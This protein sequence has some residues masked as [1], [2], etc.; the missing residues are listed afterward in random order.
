MKIKLYNIV[1]NLMRFYAIG[2]QSP[3]NAFSRK[4]IIGK[5]SAEMLNFL[6]VQHGGAHGGAATPYRLIYLGGL[7]HFCEK[8]TFFSL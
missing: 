7:P 5:I 3:N 1:G 4:M 8:P 6:M 2:L